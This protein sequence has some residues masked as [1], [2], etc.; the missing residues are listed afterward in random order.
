MN[1]LCEQLKLGLRKTYPQPKRYNDKYPYDIFD[2]TK[3]SVEGKRKNL[4]KIYRTS[5]CSSDVL[6][7][8]TSAKAV[9]TS[10]ISKSD[11][12][13]DSDKK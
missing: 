13:K 6:R 1:Y 3:T 11:I 4:L 12:L 7:L 5:W 8:L 2:Y 9:K 10:I